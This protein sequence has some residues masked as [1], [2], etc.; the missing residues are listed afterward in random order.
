MEASEVLRLHSHYSNLRNYYLEIK[1]DYQKALEME[2][3]RD[4]LERDYPKY[5][6]PLPF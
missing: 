6:E 5:F 3:K 4:E 1:Y 2:E